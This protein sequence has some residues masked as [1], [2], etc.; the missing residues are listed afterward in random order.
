MNNIHCQMPAFRGKADIS[1]YK[2]RP[3]P[4]LQVGKVSRY[5]GLF[6][7]AP[8]A[9]KKESQKQDQGKAQETPGHQGDH[10]QKDRRQKKA[11]EESAGP[12]LINQ[13]SHASRERRGQTEVGRPVSSHTDAQPAREARPAGGAYRG[14]DPLLQ[15]PVGRDP[16]AR[17]Q[18]PR[19]GEVIH[20]RGHTTDLSQRVEFLE[21]NHAPATEV[22]PNDDFGLKVVGHVREH[23]VLYRVR[24]VAPQ[25]TCPPRSSSRLDEQLMGGDDEHEDDPGSDGTP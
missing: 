12:A 21:V 4:T 16:T 13:E 18:M 2:P 14:C 5:D 3:L 10:P 11:G 9:D 1:A 22:G 15:P 25:G 6:E 20:I 8:N 7:E 17:V 23:D 24:A 19:V